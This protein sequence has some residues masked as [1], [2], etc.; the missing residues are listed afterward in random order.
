MTVKLAAPTSV[1]L[2]FTEVAPVK[3]VP[4]IVTVAPII[5]EAGVKL[6]TVGAPT[7]VNN[8]ELDP[9]PAGVVT[10]MTPLPAP[11]GTLAVI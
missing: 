3:L 5:P 8:V 9:P 2:N 7:I 4:V 10:V 6:V 1:V 11:A